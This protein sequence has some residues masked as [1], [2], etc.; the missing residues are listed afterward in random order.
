MSWEASTYV[1]GIKVGSAARKLVLMGYANHAHKDGT[2]AFPGIPTIMEYA[3][4][5][6][7]TAQR[8]VAGL[9]ED[10]F[11]RE[12]DQQLV[13][14]YP[15]NKRPI[16]YDIAMSEET[17]Q[18]WA[19]HHHMGGNA[20]RQSAAAAGSKGGK[21][22]AEN[23]AAKKAREAGN[24]ANAQVSG[25]VKMAPQDVVSSA[26]D[27]STGWGVNLT[28]QESA[29]GGVNS[30][31]AGVSSEAARGV[32]GDTQTTQATT[33]VETNPPTVPPATDPHAAADATASPDGAASRTKRGTRLDPTK[34]VITP[35][36]VTWAR[37][38]TPAVDGRAATAAFID[39]F[40]SLPGQRGL[41][42]DWVATWRNWMRTEQDR[43]A[44]RSGG[45]RAPAYSDQ[46]TW[47]ER[48]AEPGPEMSQAE[49]AALFGTDVEP[50]RQQHPQAG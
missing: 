45:N 41:K 34:F 47:G 15:E 46:H 35:D 14:H 27:T 1:L 10:G 31:A 29:A 37:E 28:P 17:R 13:S 33:Q 49:A 30:D 6:R 11:M 42:L 50:E 20:I 40:T 2:A 26:G 16:V 4:C 25:G 18:E 36:M 22:S 23:A 9:V 43:A 19:A 44:R 24:D 3:E 8:H 48:A 39:Y 21:K 38:H 7:S 12:G 5:S 32:T